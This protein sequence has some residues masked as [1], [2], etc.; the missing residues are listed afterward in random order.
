MAVALAKPQNFPLNQQYY[1]QQQYNPYNNP[2]AYKNQAYNPQAYNPQAYNN[3]A[4]YN[5]GYNRAAI[6]ITSQTQEVNP[7][8]SYQ[9]R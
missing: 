9:F 5:Q 8:G 4:Y 6:P 7:D 3:P 1:N 2:L